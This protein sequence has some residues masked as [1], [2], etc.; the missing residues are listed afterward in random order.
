VETGIIGA[1]KQK[2]AAAANNYNK[3][4]GTTGMIKKKY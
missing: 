2:G 3:M 4:P 1:E